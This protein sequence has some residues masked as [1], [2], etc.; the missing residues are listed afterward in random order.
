MAFRSLTPFG[1]SPVP[2]REDRDDFFSW[3]RDIDRAFEDMF[4]NFGSLP[5]VWGSGTAAPKIDVKETKD[6]IEVTAEL[7]GVDE[8]DVEVEINDD[9][10]TIHGEKKIERDEEDKETGYHVME[11]SYG[12]FH[13][14]VRLPFSADSGK[15]AAE[16][17][18]GVLKITCPRPANVQPKAQ[19]VSIQSR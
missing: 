13:R 4:K 11:R 16:F 1:R 17:G 8:K 14:S 6:G 2:S 15:I 9:L 12:S 7:P 3:R 18:K 5:A 19:K 10:L